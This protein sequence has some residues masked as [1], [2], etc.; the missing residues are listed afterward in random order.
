MPAATD[1]RIA[2]AIDYVNA[3]TR[4]TIDEWLATGAMA[5]ELAFDHEPP[6]VELY[7]GNIIVSQHF[8]FI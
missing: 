5:N 6:S 1:P 4:A 3:C 7:R 8:Q 2:Q